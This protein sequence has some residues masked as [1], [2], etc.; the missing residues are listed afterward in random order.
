MN[1]F[2]G[3][4]PLNSFL[5]KLIFLTLPEK[6]SILET[7]SKVSLESTIFQGESFFVRITRIGGKSKHI[8]TSRLEEEIGEVIYNRTKDSRVEF[9]NPRRKFRG[10]LTSKRFCFGLEIAKKPAGWFKPRMAGKKPFFQPSSLQP[11]LARCMVNLTS[12]RNGD[13]VL[14]PFCGT[15]TT[16]MEAALMGYETVGFDVLK[17][18]INGSRVN[19]NYFGSRRFHLL[20]ASAL[21]FPFRRV[22]RIATDP[23]YGHST[24]TKGLETQEIISRFLKEASETMHAGDRICFAAPDV[25]VVT[26]ILEPGHW[27]IKD[28]HK[29]Y[30]HRSL[31][32]QI[33]VLERM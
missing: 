25:I 32:R 18:M 11:K 31:T 28:M 14:D 29:V 12:P 3:I 22:Q 10:F 13:L 4:W 7:I 23:P 21:H 2:G 1:K 5:N 15:G 17:K 30:V 26:H 33:I 19:L 24:T 27:Q 9:K 16:L 20:L 8:S 6:K